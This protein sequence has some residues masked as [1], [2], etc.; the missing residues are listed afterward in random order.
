MPLMVGYLWIALIHQFSADKEEPLWQHP[1][2]W[3]RFL[4]TKNNVFG[5]PPKRDRSG[6]ERS[7]LAFKEAPTKI[8]G[9]RRGGLWIEQK[10][11][12]D[13]EGIDYRRDRPGWGLSGR[14][15]LRQ[16]L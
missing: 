2:T 16:R 1:G 15:T 5:R 9:D 8:M 14:V 7:R 6:A 3:E 10:K 4:E 11:G 12:H 13:E